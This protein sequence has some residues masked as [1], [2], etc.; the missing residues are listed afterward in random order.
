MTPRELDILRLV[1]TGSTNR[2]IARRIHVSEGTVKNHVSRILTR[3]GLRDR[4]QAAVYA[5][6]RGLL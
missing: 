5:R 3:L 4:T 1:A 2:E 6:D